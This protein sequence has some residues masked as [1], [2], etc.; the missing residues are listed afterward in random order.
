MSCPPELLEKI[1]MHR[2]SLRQGPQHQQWIGEWWA[3]LLPDDRRTFLALAGLDDS[4]EMARRPWEQYVTA[5]RE[6]LMTECKRIQRL[7]DPIKWA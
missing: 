6:A 4:I 5:H 3:R 7:V 2:E 1:K